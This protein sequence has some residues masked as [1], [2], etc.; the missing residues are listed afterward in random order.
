M[1]L[2][3]II[4]SLPDKDLRGPAGTRAKTM[5]LLAGWTGQ[6]AWQ[7]GTVLQIVAGSRAKGCNY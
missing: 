3:P 5:H 6:S 2:I 7:L 4:A 1:F